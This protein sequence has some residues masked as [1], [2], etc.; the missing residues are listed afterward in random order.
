M[1]GT[2][3]RTMK[4]QKAFTRREVLKTAISAAVIFGVTGSSGKT[5]AAQLNIVN[6]LS[7][8]NRTRP[9]RPFTR[10]IVLHTTEGKEV[11]SLNKLV[12]YGEAHYFVALSGK[13]HRI[14][15]KSKIAK[16]AGRSMWEG[17]STLDNYSIGIEVSGYHNH[18]IS[19]AQYESLRELLRQLKSLYKIPDNRVL[20]H[21]MVAYGRPN[22]FHDDNHRGRKRCGMMF[23]DHKVR[24]RIGL[25]AAPDRD[26]DVEAGRL[27]IADKELYQYL[28]AAAKIAPAAATKTV[29]AQ[30][31][32]KKPVSSSNAE[33]TMPE[34]PETEIAATP[35]PTDATS[36]KSTTAKPSTATA[37]KPVP[38]S[39]T[40]TGDTSLLANMPSESPLIGND[41]TAWQIAREYYNASSTVY[42]FPDGRRLN[43]SQI[44]DWGR[45]PVGTRV[46]LGETEGAQE[47]EGFLEIGKDGDTPQALAGKAYAS[48]T[49]IY[50][51]PNGLIRTGAE[52][53]RQKSYRSLF[54]NP[55]KGTRLLVGYVY[56][57]YVRQRRRPS[58][59]AGTKW[60]YPSTYYRYPDGSILSGDDI[61]DRAVPVGTLVF[62]Q[63]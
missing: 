53:E 20:T 23:A 37:I 43:G 18:D 36:S 49:T 7:P 17:Q 33:T 2:T 5:F 42:E 26:A 41:R 6:Q 29:V 27:K 14:I 55:P 34:K 50:F 12:R 25:T 35:A 24:T 52:L 62:Y 38:K 10:Y 46:I 45:I 31:P 3:T 16:H 58:S 28:F 59:I 57:G 60:N 51:F 39:P 11:G 54:K 9:A 48:K 21:S 44:K 4:D 40:E 19:A 15:D 30:S 63:E 32:D 61:N 1:V 56:G 22:R 8:L 13:V 47:F